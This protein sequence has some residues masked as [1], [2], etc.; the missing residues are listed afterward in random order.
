VVETETEPPHTEVPGAGG[1]ESEGRVLELL[2][3]A[4]ADFCKY[5]CSIDTVNFRDTLMF[6][7][8]VF[9]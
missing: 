2:V 6:Q 7:T 3:S 9:E 5:K 8:R 4:T 1:A